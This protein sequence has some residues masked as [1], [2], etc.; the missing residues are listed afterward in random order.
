[1]YTLEE[2]KNFLKKTNFWKKFHSYTLIVTISFAMAIAIVTF[3]DISYKKTAFLVLVPFNFISL[4]FFL[5]SEQK[6]S[7]YKIKYGNI[8]IKEKDNSAIVEFFDEF[9]YLSVTMF[10]LNGV[11]HNEDGFAIEDNIGMFEGKEELIADDDIYGSFFLEGVKI[12][13]NSLEEF[14]NISKINN[15]TKNF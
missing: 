5:F 12:K 4:F 6:S 3:L 8:K 1:M 10:F 2:C 15:I 14:L 9:G 13:A 7:F 11:L